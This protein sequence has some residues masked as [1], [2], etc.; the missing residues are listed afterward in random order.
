MSLHFSHDLNLIASLNVNS[1][2]FHILSEPYFVYAIYIVKGLVTMMTLISEKVWEPHE[3]IY[4]SKFDFHTYS[5]PLNSNNSRKVAKYC[6]I[7]RDKRRI[8]MEV[9]SFKSIASSWIIH[10]WIY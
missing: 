8:N 6:L 1:F 5:T 4:W 3:V 10:L 9:S 7:L 2:R